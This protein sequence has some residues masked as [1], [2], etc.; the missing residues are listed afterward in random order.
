MLCTQIGMTP[1]TCRRS[2]DSS[3]CHVLHLPN[4]QVS[5]PQGQAGPVKHKLADAF[6]AEAT[7]QNPVT[8]AV[9]AAW[10]KL[11]HAN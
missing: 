11:Q 7:L 2:L 9:M 5:N 3:E 10:R 6:W 4:W 8:H 1:V